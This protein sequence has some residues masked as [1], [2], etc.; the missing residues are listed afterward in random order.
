MDE[1]R[2]P[3]PLA[4]G[5]SAVCGFVLVGGLAFILMGSKPEPITAP[6]A[7]KPYTAADKAFRCE[8]PDGWEQSGG[9]RMGVASNGKFTKGAAVIEVDAD[10]TGSL[11]FDMPTPGG[12]D[13][14]SGDPGASGAGMPDLSSIPGMEKLA[15]VDLKMDRRPPVEKLHEA[16][17]KAFAAEM[18]G[19]G[20]SE[21]EEAAPQAFRSQIGDAR[22][23]A[24]T[25]QGNMFV[26]KV[27]GYRASIMGGERAIY[28][29]CQAPEKDW[30]KVD[31]AFQRV[32]GSIAPG[33]G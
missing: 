24:Y 19:R 15:G 12:V 1:A 31:K 23:S 2:N 14:A 18:K 17:K 30:P 9:S 7:F 8:Y 32:I 22:W 11:L 20:I 6:T 4:G 16:R 28:V 13:P 27:K 21:V 29:N 33:G 5:L 26:G 10:L 25:A 3:W